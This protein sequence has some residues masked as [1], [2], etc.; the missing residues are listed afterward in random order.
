MRRLWTGWDWRIQDGWSL[1][2]LASLSGLRSYLALSRKHRYL[3]GANNINIL[4]ILSQLKSLRWHFIDIW[5]SKKKNKLLLCEQLE[6]D[7]SLRNR[8]GRG[9]E[10]KNQQGETYFRLSGY[11]AWSLS[12]V[13]IILYNRKNKKQAF[14]QMKRLSNIKMWR[15]GAVEVHWCMR[16]TIQPP[17]YDR[18]GYSRL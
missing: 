17:P 13:E 2:R 16:Q 10:Q 1:K 4:Y 12:D 18:N 14:T 5:T 15:L 7:N 6:S 8:A 3:L 9:R 11:T